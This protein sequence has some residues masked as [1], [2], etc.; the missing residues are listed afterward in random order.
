MKEQ[1]N[2]TL[3]PDEARAVL[4]TNYSLKVGMQ[5]SLLFSCLDAIGK[6]APS[7]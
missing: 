1:T 6:G 5:P 3:G 7:F 4:R 2:N